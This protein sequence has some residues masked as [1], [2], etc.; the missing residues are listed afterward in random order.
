ME[1]TRASESAR[2]AYTGASGASCRSVPEPEEYSSNGD[3]GLFRVVG[4]CREGP[5]LFL[6][7]ESP[8]QVSSGAYDAQWHQ[9]VLSVGRKREEHGRRAI[10]RLCH[11]SGPERTDHQE[12][13]SEEVVS[14]ASFQEVRSQ[15]LDP[16]AGRRIGEADVPG[17]KDLPLLKKGRLAWENFEAGELFGD[18]SFAQRGTNRLLLH[19]VGDNTLLRS[20]LPAVEFFLEEVERFNIPV[21]TAAQ[22]DEGIADVLCLWC[23]T[24]K[25][26]YQTGLDLVSGF[27]HVFPEYRGKLDLA[28]RAR[29]AWEDLAVKGEGYPPPKEAVLT[30]I[31]HLC[32]NGRADRALC[33]WLMMDAYL[34]QQDWQQIRKEDV[35]D[36]GQ[37]MSILFGRRERGESSKTGVQQGVIVE[38]PW[39]VEA[40][41][42]WLLSVGDGEKVFQ[43]TDVHLRAAWNAAQVALGL[44]LGPVHNLRHCGPAEDAELHVK[45]PGQGKTLE[46]IRR[47][48][49][50]KN[51][52]SVARYSK[53]YLLAFQ[54]ARIPQAVMERGAFLR[55][56]Q[57]LLLEPIIDMVEQRLLGARAAAAPKRIQKKKAQTCCVRRRR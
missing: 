33:I 6:S 13:T 12:R 34:R 42:I 41:R 40:L 48:G 29:L 20:Y 49:R 38:N 9:G 43:F 25:R 57:G 17:P 19:K 5:E 56:H 14:Q 7:F 8:L 47:R 11:W 54:R 1:A 39:V 26:G 18:Q 27:A 22:V 3:H 52:D 35:A 44:E 55:S 31:E 46:E 37:N 4:M 53:D 28:R 45:K 15:R 2:D 24:G 50:W 21:D 10:Q 51:M 32:K 16:N 36:D 30:I 23:Y